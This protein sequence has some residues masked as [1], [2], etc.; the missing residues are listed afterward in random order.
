M[1]SFTLGKLAEIHIQG[2]VDGA[3]KVRTARRAT[4]P[5]RAPRPKHRVE[6]HKKSANR[7]CPSAAMAK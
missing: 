7:T 5:C 4:S 6:W 2:L 1:N 3:D